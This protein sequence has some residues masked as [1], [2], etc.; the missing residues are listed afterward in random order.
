M[1]DNFHA[2]A[3]DASPA[4]F[5]FH[6]GV[7]AFRI[8]AAGVQ[9]VG[10]GKIVVEIKP[11]IKAWSERVAVQDHG[12]DERGSP[13]AL[14]LQ[15]VRSGDMLRR[16]WD[17]KIGDAVHAGQQAGQDRDVGRIRNRAM[18]ERLRETDAIGGKRVKRGGF[19]LL[20]SVAPNVIGPQRIDGDEE[21]VW[22]VS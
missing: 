17:T 15:Q 18:R 16:E 20:V 9:A 21:D 3:L 7:L 13:G 10:L 4:L 14:L 8:L 11:A 22:K 12:S 1:L 19:D 6:I 5:L 2:A